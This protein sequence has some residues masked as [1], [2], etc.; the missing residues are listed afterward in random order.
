VAQIVAG[1]P[2]V[3]ESVSGINLGKLMEKL[4]GMG[5]KEG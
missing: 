1:L 2:P 3:V 5:K 4:P